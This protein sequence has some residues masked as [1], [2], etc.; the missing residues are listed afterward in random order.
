M[1]VLAGSPCSSSAQSRTALQA[2]TT[3]GRWLYE[4]DAAC[5]VATDTVLA[6][7]PDSSRLGIYVALQVA[8]RW[9]VVFGRVDSSSFEISYEVVL[10]SSQRVEAYANHSPAILA[11]D[12]LLRAARALASGLAA[13]GPRQHPYNPMVLPSSDSAW[14]VYLVPAETSSDSVYIGADVR[15]VVSADGLSIK[16]ATGLHQGLL[17]MAKIPP[18]AGIPALLHNHTLIDAPVETDVFYVLRQRPRVR[19]Y[20]GAGNRVF[21]I[22]VNGDIRLL[23]DP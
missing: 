8:S 23:S 14:V 6:S 22:E 19:H 4:Y 2:L 5:S 15:Y 18:D 21:A 17:A 10:D 9:I 13:F 1:L 12:I 7:H 11:P 3:Y 20:V 16:Q